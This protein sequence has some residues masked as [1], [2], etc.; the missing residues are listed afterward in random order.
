MKIRFYV[1]LF[2]GVDPLRHAMFANTSPGAKTEGSKRLAFDVA[3]PDAM[4]FG[5]DAISPEVGKVEIVE[6]HEGF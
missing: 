4:L 2:P 5:I 1:D 3:I 6:D